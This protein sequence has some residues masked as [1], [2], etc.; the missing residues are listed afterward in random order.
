MQISSTVWKCFQDSWLCGCQ[1]VQRSHSKLTWVWAHSWV[2]VP[3]LA[4]ETIHLK[5][6]FLGTRQVVSVIQAES[7]FM[8]TWLLLKV[9]YEQLQHLFGGRER[10]QSIHSTVKYVA[11]VLFAVT[12][13]INRL[14]VKENPWIRIQ[15]NGQQIVKWDLTICSHYICFRCCGR[16]RAPLERVAAEKHIQFHHLWKAELFKTIMLLYAGL[17]WLSI[18]LI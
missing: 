17:Y 13:M 14:W 15:S 1:V 3:I 16:P 8:H 4:Y 12:Y 11:S 6:L 18:I 2:C 7:Y 10:F 9:K 5:L